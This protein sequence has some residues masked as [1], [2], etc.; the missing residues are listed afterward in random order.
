MS[1]SRIYRGGILISKE[2]IM[3]VMVISVSPGTAI[4]QK[5][6]E[7]LD[8]G[9]VHE[10]W[11]PTSPSTSQQ[12]NELELTAYLMQI[13]LQADLVI[14]APQLALGLNGEEKQEI[15]ED[16]LKEVITRLEKTAKELP[17]SHIIMICSPLFAEKFHAVLCPQDQGED[18]IS[19]VTVYSFISGNNGL[20]SIDQ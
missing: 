20:W 14:A 19:V 10:I 1:R 8:K 12:P 2:G 15:V 9:L 11:A 3:Q 17:E 6:Y 13:H 7:R 18:N 16:P 5:L 4:L